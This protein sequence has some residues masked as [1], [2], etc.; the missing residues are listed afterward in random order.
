MYND[1]MKWDTT[2]THKLKQDRLSGFCPSFHPDFETSSGAFIEATMS[3]DL[4]F[5]RTEIINTNNSS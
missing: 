1:W 2:M 5:I 3:K 4:F